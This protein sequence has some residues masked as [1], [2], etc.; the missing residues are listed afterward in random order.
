MSRKRPKSAGGEDDFELRPKRSRGLPWKV[1]DALNLQVAIINQCWALFRVW[2][3]F[4]M[5]SWDFARL[6]SVP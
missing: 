6:C 2:Q 5:S 1:P 4:P 3:Y